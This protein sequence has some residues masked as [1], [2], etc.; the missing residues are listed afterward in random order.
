MLNRNKVIWGVLAECGFTVVIMAL[1][2]AF[3]YFISY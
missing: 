2:L 3:G 1:T